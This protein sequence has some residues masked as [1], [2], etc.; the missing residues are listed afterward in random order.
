MSDFHVLGEDCLYQTGDVD[1]IF[2]GRENL[3][4]WKWWLFSDNN[5]ERK[6]LSHNHLG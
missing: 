3:L 2:V 1:E 4:T 5:K 6:H